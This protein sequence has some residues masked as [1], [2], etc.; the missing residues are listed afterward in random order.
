LPASVFGPVAVVPAVIFFTPA[1]SSR[2]SEI[3]MLMILIPSK[4]S[5][6]GGSEHPADAGKAR[7]GETPTQG[8]DACVA[9]MRLSSWSATMPSG[10]GFATRTAV[11]LGGLPLVITT[12]DRRASRRGARGGGQ[13]PSSTHG[14][15]G[16]PLGRDNP[17]ATPEAA[18]RY[19]T[20]ERSEEQALVL[21]RG[22]DMGVTFANG[23]V[24][25]FALE[26][27]FVSRLTSRWM[28]QAGGDYMASWTE[29]FR[30]LAGQV[31][32]PAG[33]TGGFAM[34]LGDVVLHTRQ[35]HVLSKK[36]FSRFTDEPATRDLVMSLRNEFNMMS[37]FATRA[38][39]ASRITEPKA[40][41]L[42][43]LSVWIGA[44]KE[45]NG[46]EEMDRRMDKFRK[47]LSALPSIEASLEELNRL[48]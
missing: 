4:A 37:V 1:E 41:E 38:A 39:R 40:M 42:A 22:A 25:F 23:L 18:R 31:D 45:A 15:P 10:L 29:F 8:R 33:P 44:E 48:N 12:G 30:D 17:L 24:Q 13:V 6:K 2:I 28:N 34:S 19:V 11:F 26:E 43:A 14:G 35:V 9:W 36:I 32:A 21:A 20:L 7:E 46:L 3:F 47:I 16:R 27:L 5:G